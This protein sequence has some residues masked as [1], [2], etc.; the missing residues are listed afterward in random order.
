MTILNA[1]NSVKMDTEI[2]WGMHSNRKPSLP[3]VVLLHN[4]VMLELQIITDDWTF[5]GKIMANLPGLEA[6]HPHTITLPTAYFTVGM[7][8]LL[9]NAELALH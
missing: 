2:N 8:F 3:V 5:S 4:P 1:Y 6:K 7:M 9:G